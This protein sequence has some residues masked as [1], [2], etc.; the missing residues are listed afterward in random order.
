MRLI[1]ISDR[2][3]E[4]LCACKVLYSTLYVECI[5][6]SAQELLKIIDS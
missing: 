3:Q 1:V 5:V 4:Y 6:V 2:I